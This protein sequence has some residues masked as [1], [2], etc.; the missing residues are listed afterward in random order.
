LTK[1]E[2]KKLQ[3]RVQDLTPA[4]PTEHEFSGPNLAS[5]I[6]QALRTLS[7]NHQKGDF[8]NPSRVIDV[9]RVAA[10]AEANTSKTWK[11]TVDFMRC[12]P[13]DEQNALACLIHDYERHGKEMKAAP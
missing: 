13:E 12:L 6:R 3:E 8:L 2:I 1:T 9:E 5:E 10:K 4:K 11:S 7:G